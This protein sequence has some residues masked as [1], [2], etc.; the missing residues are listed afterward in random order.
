VAARRIARLRGLA[1]P[2]VN[3]ASPDA[4]FATEAVRAGLL[5]SGAEGHVT[6]PYWVMSLIRPYADAE[7]ALR[8]GPLAGAAGNLTAKKETPCRSP[9]GPADQAGRPPRPGSHLRRGVRAPEGQGPGGLTMTGCARRT[10]CPRAG[11]GCGSSS[12]PPASPLHPRQGVSGRAQ[13]YVDASSSPTT[14]SCSPPP[15]LTWVAHR[16]TA[17]SIQQTGS[18]EAAR[19]HRGW[20]EI[21]SAQAAGPDGPPRRGGWLLACGSC[22]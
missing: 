9:R 19:S 4:S 12:R 16:K 21:R 14:S 11:T 22:S 7:P 1:V 20:G 10:Q 15:S 2:P 18:V 8:A 17:T 5:A 13:P 3:Q 6:Y